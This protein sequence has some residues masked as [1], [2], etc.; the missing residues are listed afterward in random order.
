MKGFYIA[1]DFSKGRKAGFMILTQ[2]EKPFKIDTLRGTVEPKGIPTMD[3]RRYFFADEWEF[4]EGYTIPELNTVNELRS[5]VN[6]VWAGWCEK[7]HRK[8]SPILLKLEVK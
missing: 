2:S 7:H 3:K 5:N 4:I 8:Y 1:G 6:E